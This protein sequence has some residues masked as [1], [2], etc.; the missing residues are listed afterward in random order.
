LNVGK[1]I[2][3]GASDEVRTDPEVIRVYLGA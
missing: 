3:H 2:K 1:M